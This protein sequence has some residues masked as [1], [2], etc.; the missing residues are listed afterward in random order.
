MLLIIY[1]DSNN[2]ILILLSI[3]FY[4]HF[5]QM[6]GTWPIWS[7]YPIDP[8]IWDPIKRSLLYN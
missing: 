4:V 5:D 1:F 6:N 3:F 2:W 8:I 7:H